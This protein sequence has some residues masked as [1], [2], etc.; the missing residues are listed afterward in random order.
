MAVITAPIVEVTVYTD[1]ARITRRGSVHL[2]AGEQTL[3]L[4]GL[5]TTVQDDSVRASGRGANAR[6]LGVDLSRDY[7]TSPP[8]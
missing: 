7:V 6:I 2:A 1:R 5:P 4:E 8:E 3:T